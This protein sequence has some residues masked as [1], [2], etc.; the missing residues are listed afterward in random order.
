MLENMPPSSRIDALAQLQRTL[1]DAIFF[2]E[3][4][5]EVEKTK[6][7][8]KQRNDPAAAAT[9]GTDHACKDEDEDENVKRQ[10]AQK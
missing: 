10:Q 8:S 7:H 5:A 1:G 4:E 3:S 9:I 2:A 6:N